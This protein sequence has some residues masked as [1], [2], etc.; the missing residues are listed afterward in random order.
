VLYRKYT[1]QGD[2]GL[3]WS[4]PKLPGRWQLVVSG[5]SVLM[6]VTM[7]NWRSPG[8]RAL[9]L[10][11]VDVRTG[12]PVSIQTAVVRSVA[13]Q[14]FSQLTRT[15]LRPWDERRRERLLA[16]HAELEGLRRTHAGGHETMERELKDV[17]KR[18]D[19][20]PAHTCLLPLAAVVPPNLAAVFSPLHQTLWERLAGTVVVED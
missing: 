9:G 19:V 20:S 3:E 15:L 4:P 8:Y 16:A 7:R 10:R 18:H 1:G 6:E 5:L 14:A 13:G 12:G 2:R 17:L 11:R